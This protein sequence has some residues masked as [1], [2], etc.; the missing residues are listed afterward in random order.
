MSLRSFLERIYKQ[1]TEQYWYSGVWTLLVAILMFALYKILDFYY[2]KILT[3]ELEFGYLVINYPGLQWVFQFF[4]FIGCGLTYFFFKA[5]NQAKTRAQEKDIDWGRIDQLTKDVQ[6]MEDQI[7]EERERYRKIIDRQHEFVTKYNPDGTITFANRANYSF[8][9][10][11][12]WSEMVGQNLFD[13]VDRFNPDIRKQVKKITKDNPRERH[14]ETMVS[15][16]GEVIYVD[17]VNCAIFGES[18]EIEK[19]QSVGR[20]ITNIVEANE[21]LRMSEEKYRLLFTHNIAGYAIHSV[22]CEDVDGRRDVVCDYM[23]LEVNPMFEQM[24]GFE[25]RNII[26]RTVLQVM[27][28]T[29]PS[30]IQRFGMVAST[31]KPDSFHCFFSDINK[32]FE[33]SA[34]RPQENHFAATFVDISEW[35]DRRGKLERVTD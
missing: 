13:L 16:D 34:F 11:T 6:E 29:E 28:S 8:H 12:H 32:W 30:L 33:V 14:I 10:F 9:G 3:G 24:F 2:G 22:V 21:R 4:A 1:G 26:G 17:W 15:H 7:R 5:Y 25:E 20:D 23:F 18:G 19:Y 31:G 27:P 35:R